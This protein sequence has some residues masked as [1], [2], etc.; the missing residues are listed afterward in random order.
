MDPSNVS[1]WNTLGEYYNFIGDLEAARCCFENAL[2]Y[3]PAN[4][5]SY[6]NLCRILRQRPYAVAQQ[7]QQQPSAAAT[8][9]TVASG[10]TGNSS[11]SSG[12]GGGGRHGK[13]RIPGVASSFF[14][15]CL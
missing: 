4:K 2:R 1:T 6:V 12:R 13:N 8:T 7:L 5:I 9:V 14:L 11:G 10:S 3:D 15:W